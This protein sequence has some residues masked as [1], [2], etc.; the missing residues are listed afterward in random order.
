MKIEINDPSKTLTF[1]VHGNFEDIVIIKQYLE[2]LPNILVL[3]L[4]EVPKFMEKDDSNSMISITCQIIS[5]N[6]VINILQDFITD[7]Y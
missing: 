5:Y 1:E 2:K 3:V 4:G 7:K 6:N